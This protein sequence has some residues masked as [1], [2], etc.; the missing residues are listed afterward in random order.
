MG[1][2]AST[3]AAAVPGEVLSAEAALP[4]AAVA[5]EP[6]R[7]GM[8]QPVQNLRDIWAG[9]Q[10]GVPGSFRTVFVAHQ[11]PD[12]RA[13]AAAIAAALGAAQAAGPAGQP[14]AAGPASLHSTHM[15]VEAPSPA[16]SEAFRVKP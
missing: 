11:G 1:A 9:R 5:G 8:L 12:G 3:A 14:V 7:A 4:T 10:G 15:R 6:P 13:A 16:W 2:A